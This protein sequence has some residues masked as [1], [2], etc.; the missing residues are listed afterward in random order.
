MTA[1]TAIELTALSATVAKLAKDARSD[2]EPGD[3][4]VG[5][6]VTLRVDGTVKVSADEDY[7]PTVAIPLKATM[8]LFMRYAGVTGPAAMDALERAMTEALSLSALTGKAKKDAETA[9]HELAD[10]S[11]A[12]AKVRKGLD[13]LPTKTRMGKVAVKAQVAEVVGAVADAASEEVAA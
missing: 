5:R 4:T 6:E 9:I 10:L 2:I 7:T 1:L 3:Y 8:A 12:E 11:A 13:A